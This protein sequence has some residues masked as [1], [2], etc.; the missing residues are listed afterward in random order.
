VQSGRGKIIGKGNCH[1]RNIWGGESMYGKCPGEC[2]GEII[3]RQISRLREC[4]GDKC[5]GG[6]SAVKSRGMSWRNEI[7]D[8]FVQ[9]YSSG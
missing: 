2:V 3:C 9:L 8:Q 1:G 6:T 5:P 4:Q 7:S